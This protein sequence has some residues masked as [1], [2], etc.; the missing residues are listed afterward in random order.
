M[1]IRALAVTVVML[2]LSGCGGI[3]DN[4]P[5][6]LRAPLWG[7]TVPDPHKG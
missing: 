1:I 3:I 6:G 5:E 4:C 2:L 7:S